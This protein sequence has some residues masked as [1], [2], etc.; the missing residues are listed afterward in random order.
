MRVE[1]GWS[2]LN[3]AFFVVRRFLPPHGDWGKVIALAT[4]TPQGKTDQRLSFS[5]EACPHDWIAEISGPLYEISPLCM[6]AHIPTAPWEQPVRYHP[7][8]V[9]AC[10]DGRKCVGRHGVRALTCTL[11]LPPAEDTAVALCFPTLGTSKDR[12]CHIQALY[13]V[14]SSRLGYLMQSSQAQKC[15]AVVVYPHGDYPNISPWSTGDGAAVSLSDQ[16][17]SGVD[18]LW[19]CSPLTRPLGP[20]VFLWKKE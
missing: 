5:P 19:S 2:F 14:F 17:T 6:S 16:W 11:T 13:S 15:H 20:N 10:T 9:R 1:E 4:A 18:H 3:L 7:G 12:V 8:R